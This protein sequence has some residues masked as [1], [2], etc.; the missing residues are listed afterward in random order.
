MTK[1]SP[2]VRGGRARM[3]LPRFSRR[4]LAPR[5]TRLYCVSAMKRARNHSHRHF[6]HDCTGGRRRAGADRRCAVC[7]PGPPTCRSVPAF[8]RLGEVAGRIPIQHLLPGRSDAERTDRSQRRHPLARPRLAQLEQA[9]VARRLRPLH[10][11]AEISRLEVVRA[12]QRDP[13]RVRRP[14]GRRDGVLCAAGHSRAAHHSHAALCQ[15]RVRR[16]LCDCRVGGQGDARAG[17]RR[18]RRR[19]AERRVSLRVQVDGRLEVRLPRRRPLRIQAA[20]RTD[21]A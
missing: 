4:T 13:G 10:H 19:H 8:G 2:K 20:I 1:I 14:R 3:I 11:R 12:R 5:L 16:P 17:V 6:A 21:H 18:H 15:Q 7:Q 9:R